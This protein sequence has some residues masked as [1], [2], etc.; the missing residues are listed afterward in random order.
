MQ[1]SNK[2]N[3]RD[4]RLTTETIEIEKNCRKL[5][6]VLRKMHET[7]HSFGTIGIETVEWVQH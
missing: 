3:E 4:M 2:K 6:A 7:W 1:N 5:N